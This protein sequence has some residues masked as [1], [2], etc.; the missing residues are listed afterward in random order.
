MILQE[1]NS[2][3]ELEVE[4]AAEAHRRVSSWFLNPWPSSPRTRLTWIL[5]WEGRI[6]TH[7]GSTSVKCVR[8][9]VNFIAYPA[10]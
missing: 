5:I 2:T 8:R 1:K 7:R 6:H 4:A 3:A 9:W 10:I